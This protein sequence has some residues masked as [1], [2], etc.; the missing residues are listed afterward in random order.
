MRFRS[1]LIAFILTLPFFIASTCARSCIDFFDSNVWSGLKLVTEPTVWDVT[2]LIKVFCE[3]FS[4]YDCLTKQD[5]GYFFD[6]SQSVF[7]SILCNHVWAWEWYISWAMFQWS[8]AILKKHTFL[9]FDIYYCTD[10]D[11][12]CVGGKYDACSSSSISKMKWCDLSYFMPKIFDPLMNDFFNIKQASNMW[13]DVL[14]DDFDKESIVNSYM[15]N[16]FP[17]LSAQ[18]WLKEWFCNSTYYPQSCKYVKNYMSQL[19]NLLKNTRV[20]DVKNL[21]AKKVDCENN[22]TW[23]ILYC[24]LLWEQKTPMIS[25]LN[26]I[27]NEY[28]WYNL[29]MSYYSYELANHPQY[30]IDYDDWLSYAAKYGLNTPNI[31]SVQENLARSKQAITMSL[32]SLS[33][34]SYTFPMHVWFLM[35]QEDIIYFMKNLPKVYTPMRTLFDKLR[36]VQDADS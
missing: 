25:F 11:D 15:N 6:A 8:G 20:I 13:I 33:E 7:L 1:V 24:G 2:K 23:N 26:A 32:R 22:F 31:Y 29:F 16:H 36:N 21:S 18:D 5:N 4:S 19:N 28:F 27:Y 35:Y 14:N 3:E 17:W 12:N 34:I 9:T 10:W 30:S